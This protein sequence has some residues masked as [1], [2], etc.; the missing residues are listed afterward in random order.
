MLTRTS[1]VT[2]ALAITAKTNVTSPEAAPSK[3]RSLTQL[4]EDEH[5]DTENTE[6]STESTKR[7]KALDGTPM[8]KLQPVSKLNL[9]TVKSTSTTPTPTPAQDHPSISTCSAK[10]SGSATAPAGRSP[11]SKKRGPLAAKRPSLAALRRINPPTKVAPRSKATQSI[12]AALNGS[13]STYMPS[14]SVRA[15]LMPGARKVVPRKLH[16]EI[17]N[18]TP[19]EEATNLMYHG[20]TTLDISSD[21]ESTSSKKICRGKENLPPPDY[22][23]QVQVDRSNMGDMIDVEK[24]R[25]PLGLLD[26]EEFYGAGLDAQSV[27]VIAPE[28]AE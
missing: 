16:F 12:G 9:K 20:T 3:K 25:S 18:D 1:A 13:L 5:V 4:Y 23:P 2:E 14:G 17:H 11:P 10:I 27:E 8:K 21:E 24:P 7:S 22:Q 6:P 15:N 19:V 26:A 28:E